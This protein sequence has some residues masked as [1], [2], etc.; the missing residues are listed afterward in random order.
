MRSD[1]VKS[2]FTWWKTLGGC[3]AGDKVP[4]RVKEEV[5]SDVQPKT[6]KRNDKVP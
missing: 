2:V 3:R 4:C 5:Y 6:A 1:P